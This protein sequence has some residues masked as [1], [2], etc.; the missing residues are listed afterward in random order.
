MWGYAAEHWTTHFEKIPQPSVHL[1][2]LALKALDPFSNPL[3]HMIWT[4]DIGSRIIDCPKK[5]EL[6]PLPLYLVASSGFSR[7]LSLLLS[8]SDIQVNSVTGHYGTALNAA[9]AHNLLPIIRMLLEAGANPFLGN[10]DYSCALALAVG[11]E[12]MYTIEFL[13]GSIENIF[14]R[15]YEVP[16]FPLAHA[17]AQGRIKIVRYLVEQ[18]ADINKVGGVW[19]NALQ[20]AATCRDEKYNQAT[21]ELLL[22]LGANVRAR[23][24]LFGNALQ[25][26]VA[27]G[28]TGVVRLLQDR[29]ANF[30]PPEWDALLV[31]IEEAIIADEGEYF[32]QEERSDPRAFTERLV[33]FRRGIETEAQSESESQRGF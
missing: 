25:A 21:V 4:R 17:A 33:A 12:N 14:S 30:D 11:Y 26:A 32:S 15:C 28:N 10:A 5:P 20:A 22:G 29:G 6:L 19:G 27:F 7:L 13:V 1:E 2:D 31:S 16:Y 8:K 18:G 24:G 3:F 9:T 23:G